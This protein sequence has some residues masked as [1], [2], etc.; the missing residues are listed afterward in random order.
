[1]NNPDIVSDPST[2]PESSPEIIP[3]DITSPDYH[4]LQQALAKR[5]H[6]HF[7][8]TDM[9]ADFVESFIPVFTNAIERTL[10]KFAAGQL[11]HGGDIRT[12]D[13]ERDETQ[14]IYDLFLYRLCKH[15]QRKV[16]NVYVD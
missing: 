10:A 9:P 13:L 4:H 1:M 3:A 11:E 14:E 12:R 15:T 5:I 16:I 7:D 8:P 6:F 2:E